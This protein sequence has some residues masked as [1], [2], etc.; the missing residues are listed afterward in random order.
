MDAAS[1]V[2]S[3]AMVSD[4]VLTDVA[5]P[6]GANG[7]LLA[8]LEPRCHRDLCCWCC[9][10]I[11]PC[12]HHQ[13]KALFEKCTTMWQRLGTKSFPVTDTNVLMALQACCVK[14]LQMLKIPV[15]PSMH[16]VPPGSTSTWLTHTMPPPPPPT[17]GARHCA[18]AASAA[19][20]STGAAPTEARCGVWAQP[21]AAAYMPSA[22]VSKSSPMDEDIVMMKYTSEQLVELKTAEWM[23]YV[24]QSPPPH[25]EPPE[26]SKWSVQFMEKKKG[27][28]WKPIADEFQE[29]YLNLIW[30]PERKGTVQVTNPQGDWRVYEVFWPWRDAGLQHNVQKHTIRQLRL[31]LQR[32]NPA[33]ARSN[34]TGGIAVDESSWPGMMWPN[35]TWHASSA[36]GGVD[37]DS[38]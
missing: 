37:V 2:S 18:S 25:R 38:D 34:P 23:A 19:S 13:Q 24:Q 15:D 16:F 3:F 33:A 35:N 6:A 20:S 29:Q 28:V 30:S 26:G 27:T 32:K 9:L 22:Q 11:E 31:I 36:S 5:M 21:D 10:D 12:D 7:S 8:A 14:E 17:S 1:T 4:A